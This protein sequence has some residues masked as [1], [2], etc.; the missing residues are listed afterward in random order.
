MKIYVVKS[1]DSIWSI[2][3]A[4]GVTPESIIRANGISEASKL[5]V[6]QTLVIPSRESAYRVRPGD[7]IYSI[8]KRFGVSVE[9]IIRLNNL[10]SP[11]TIS[12][13]Q[14]IRIPEKSKNYG[15]IEVNAFIQPSTPERERRVMAEGIPYLTYITPFSHQV[16]ADGSLTPLNDATILQVAK[17]NRVAPMLSVTN[18]SGANFDTNLVSRILNDNLLQQTVI[19]NILGLLRGKG[20]Y[21]VIIDFERI[22]PADRQKYNDFLRKL[23]ERLHPNYVVGTALAPKTYDVTTGSW[24]GAHDYR[25]HGQIVDFV[26]IM[27]YEWGWSGGADQNNCYRSKSKKPAI[28]FYLNPTLFCQL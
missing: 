27:T 14:I 16:N 10:S 28:H 3:R 11:Y 1:G 7:S 13:G 9:S 2:S 26:V 8:A 22:P 17:A 6:G 19:N 5:V 12:P 20:Y 24:H 18:I 15:Y 21:G 25:A 23:V 4:F